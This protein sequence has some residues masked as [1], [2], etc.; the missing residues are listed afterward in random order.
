MRAPWHALHIWGFF[1]I[2]RAASNP[3]PWGLK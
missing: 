2:D 3:G 1:L